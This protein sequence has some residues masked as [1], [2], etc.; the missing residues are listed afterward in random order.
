MPVPRLKMRGARQEGRE[1]VQGEASA[2]VFVAG[3]SRRLLSD[4]LAS[5]A[6]GLCPMAECG[7][8]DESSES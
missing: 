2:V 4:K 1:Y 5:E 3:R 6:E 7:T 8:R